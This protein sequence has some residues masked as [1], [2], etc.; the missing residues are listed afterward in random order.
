MSP[1]GRQLA[2]W[3][4][5]VELVDVADELRAL[6]PM[7]LLDTVGLIMA[8]SAT[9][10]VKTARSVAE[11]LGGRAESTV[12]GSAHRLPSSSAALVHGVAAH[13]HDFDDTFPE[14]VVHPGS[15]VIPTAIAVSE[16]MDADNA[17]FCA[18]IAVGYELAARIGAAAGRR[19]HARNMH[20]T[21]FVGPLVAA[22]VAGRLRRLVPQQISWAMGL[23]ASMS[24]GIRAYSKDG[25]W[26]KWLHVGWAAHGGILAADLAARG[27]RGPEY[28]LDGGSDLYSAMLY[29]DAVDRSALLTDL[30]RT[31]RATE[32]EF[33]YYP[34]AHVIH[35]FTNALLTLVGE[36]DLHADDIDAIECTIAPWAAAIVC[37]PADAKLRFTTEL[38]AT[39]S[40]PYQLSVAVLDGNVGLNALHSTTRN[41]TDIAEFARRISYRKDESCGRE[42]GG[43]IEIRTKSRQT[44]ACDAILPA[45]DVS[46]L[47]D[48]FIGLVEPV[49]GPI[50]AV[51]A[52]ARLLES[53]A[54][55]RSAVDLL[56]S[57]KT[58]E[59]ETPG[60]GVTAASKS[61]E[62]CG[63]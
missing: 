23:S 49:L 53:P 25:G 37:E 36:H 10:A 17:D 60:P 29:G 46:K 59:P 6:A 9:A 14:S 33:K 48:K 58:D 2:E 20:A 8:G 52:A 28:V 27:F 24:S 54:D 56:R 32:A 44:Y 4:A 34:C 30:G 45:N 15:V 18:A 26:S 47:R 5:G 7:R 19:F 55:W 21:G 42:F 13:C 50:S 57:V 12:I 61:P 63:R 43:Q 38:E 35:P 51:D 40:L 62:E 22:A 39:G 3:C 41:R 1:L 16:V 11:G 31:W